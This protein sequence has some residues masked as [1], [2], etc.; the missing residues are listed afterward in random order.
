MPA[1]SASA[2][3][4]II[5]FGEHAVVY[6]RPA[7]AVPVSQLRAKAIITPRPGAP[8]GEVAIQADQVKLESTLEAL[9]ED[10]PIAKAVRLTLSALGIER[11][12][13][14]KLKVTSTIPVAAGLGSGAA[15]SVAIMRAVSGFLGHPLAD[16][17]VSALAFE[18]EK[19]HHGTPSGIDNSVVTYE[20]PVYFVKDQGIQSFAVPEPFTIVIADTGVPTPTAVTVGAV[21]QA[22]QAD[23]Q[24]YE[25]LFDAV[26]AIA[27]QARQLIESGHPE[28]LG[29]LMDENQSLLMKMGISSPELDRLVEHA[30]AA[31]ARGAKLSGGGRGG[32]VIALVD[33]GNAPT[34]AEAL[35]A[36]GAKSTFTT[37]IGA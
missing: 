21:R 24:S 4:K 1:I 11:A 12:P 8:S 18:V 6:G 16:E 22:W 31:G 9:P 28:Q 29:T 30:R 27:E 10:D 13:A 37:T 3:G 7:I 23:P 17:Q 2:P 14:F 26:G 15:V 20:Q 19:L 32:N 35:S 5:L 33:E 25:A 34:V 36:A